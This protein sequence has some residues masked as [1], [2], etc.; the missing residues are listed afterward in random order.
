MV[1]QPAPEI[2]KLD[3]GYRSANT[4]IFFR[5]KFVFSRIHQDPI[6]IDITLVV[7]RF[8][9]LAAII[10]SDRIGPDVLLSL[11]NFLPIVLPV[12]SV[13]VEIVIDT[14]FEA[15]PDRR[16]RIG[17]RSINYNR[18]GSRAAAVVDPILSSSSE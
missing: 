5:V 7:D 15:C 16:T 10:E 1:L 6:A 12:D 3:G 14:M 4:A 18:T 8:I 17:S 9:W 11:T 2:G 13:P